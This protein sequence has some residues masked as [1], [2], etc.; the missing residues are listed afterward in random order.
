[1]PL[2]AT[3]STG[4]G[5]RGTTVAVT[6]IA[7]RGSGTWSPP[8][9]YGVGGRDG[10][11][12][13]SAS[14]RSS[15]SMREIDIAGEISLSVRRVGGPDPPLTSMY[16]VNGPDVR[17]PGLS[18]TATRASLGGRVHDD[19]SP[20]RHGLSRGASAGAEVPRPGRAVLSGRRNLERPGHGPG[21]SFRLN[22][23]H[24]FPAPQGGNQCE[25]PVVVR[26]VQRERG[27]DH[28][29]RG[30]QPTGEF[31]IDRDGSGVGTGPASERFGGGV[32]ASRVRRL[33]RVGA[34]LGRCLN[35]PTAVTHLRRARQWS[36][37]CL[38]SSERPPREPGENPH[39]LPA[40]EVGRGNQRR[41]GRAGQVG[42]SCR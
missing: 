31:G 35:P 34:Q 13:T 26:L 33:G 38:G 28:L 22:E 37:A 12:A 5:G 14:R 42:E 4:M 40:G 11:K 6:G 2:P 41:P 8:N 19:I 15:S 16:S 30:N 3:G 32:S 7:S 24:R 29:Q 21:R 39:R 36:A 10:P 20:R 25:R 18:T 23:G 27:A 9:C 17:F 1:M